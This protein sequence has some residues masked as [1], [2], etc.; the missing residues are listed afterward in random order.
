[1]LRARKEAPSSQPAR[2]YQSQL[3][4]SG[5]WKLNCKRTLLFPLLKLN[6]RSYPSSDASAKM[7]NWYTSHLC[8]SHGTL[9]ICALLIC[10]FGRW[11]YQPYTWCTDVT[12][13][14]LC[15]SHVAHVT[16]SDLITPASY[17]K[18]PSGKTNIAGWKIPIFKQ[19]IHLQ[20]IQMVD[21]PT[22]YVSFTGG[23][24]FLPQA[25]KVRS[26]RGK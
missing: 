13:I 22:S 5:A 10:A 21:F 23:V 15:V 9:L 3:N 6:D 2:R 1:M 12:T 18:L 26:T 7:A 14:I 17:H 8:T 24:N 11:S 25:S 16:V 19:E 4:R 20:M